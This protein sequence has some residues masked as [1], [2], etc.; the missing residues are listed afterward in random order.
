M[1][2]L[3]E[4][5]E[6]GALQ[7]S[8][9]R[10]KKALSEAAL[11]PT[12][13]EIDLSA[14][15]HNHRQLTA[16]A[17]PSRVLSVVKADGYGHGAVEVARCLEAAGAFGF[18]VALAEEGLELRE[19]GVRGAVFVL[20]GVYGNAHRE[21]LQQGLT[22]ILYAMR[23]ARA[24]QRM[25]DD[26]RVS[27]HLK[28]DTGMSR[29]GVGFEDVPRFLDQLRDTPKIQIAGL[30]THFAASDSDPEFTTLQLLRLQSALEQIRDAGHPVGCVHA[31]NSGGCIR[32]DARL[33]LVRAGIALYGVA[34][35]NWAASGRALP[36]LRPTMRLRSEI[37]SMRTLKKGDSVGYDR[38]F[39]ADRDGVRVAVAPVGYGDG[40]LWRE[41]TTGRDRMVLVQGKRCPIAGRV[42]MDLTTIDVTDVP[43]ADV[44]DEVVLLGS[45]QG[46]QLTVEAQASGAGTIPY[47]VLTNV[48]RRVPR[49]YCR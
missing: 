25:A 45:Q 35:Q 9:S 26:R 27:V 42:S 3:L 14:L 41:P 37:V 6:H 4:P 22:P 29:L 1:F 7:R 11:R 23:D 24:F 46:Q 5:T 10:P 12:R 40:M 32:L 20:N 28:V 2:P 33:D 48:S 15:V 17:G 8:P 44:G 49:L 39:V 16:L 43:A 34:P 19:A 47:E 21:V 18:G 38:T 30:M 13:A 31:A 36:V